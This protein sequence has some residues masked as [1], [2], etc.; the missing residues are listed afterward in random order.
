MVGGT[1]AGNR[2]SAPPAYWT[3]QDSAWQSKGRTTMNVL[4]AVASRHGSTREIAQAVAVELRHAG[5]SVDVR[6]ARHVDDVGP[7]GAVII[8]S[9]VYM[10]NWLSEGSQLVDRARTQLAALP[11]WLFSSGPIGATDPK[12]KGDP[13]HIDELA[14]SIQA[15]GHRSFVGKLDKGHLGMGERLIAGVV[16][17]PAGDFRDWDAIRGW[18]RDIAAALQTPAGS[19]A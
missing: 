18:A 15:R 2:V 1:R 11:V 5:H 12:P 6:D 9:A 14:K 7:Y 8:G 19:G 16:R 13:S 17:T 3:A 4:V 10:G